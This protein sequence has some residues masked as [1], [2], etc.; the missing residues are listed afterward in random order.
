MSNRHAIV[1]G[2]EVVNVILL[3]DG[4]DYKPGEGQS[5]HRVPEDVSPGW[6][7]VNEEWVEPEAPPAEVI[8]PAIG[9]A[10]KDAKEAAASEL[11]NI[12]IT[13][14]SARLIVGLH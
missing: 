3:N 5:I 10:V 6:Q 2:N 12:G 1:E 9:K 7:R 4:D 14:A 11:M 8:D 13:E